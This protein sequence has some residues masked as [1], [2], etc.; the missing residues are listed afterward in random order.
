MKRCRSDVSI[1][2]DCLLGRR[3]IS[4]ALNSKYSDESSCHKSD[5]GNGKNGSFVKKAWFACST[6]SAVMNIGEHSLKA[7]IH[8]AIDSIVC[9][10]LVAAGRPARNKLNASTVRLRDQCNT[11][12][13]LAV[14]MQNV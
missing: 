7:S 2:F 14:E 13:I 12:S 8:G 9:G 1:L 4:F 5:F 10:D 3:Q 6:L 11:A